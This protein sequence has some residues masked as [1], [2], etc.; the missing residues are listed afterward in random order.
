MLHCACLLFLLPY[1]YC[2]PHSIHLLLFTL[3]SKGR[4]LTSILQ[5]ARHTL[6]LKA[7][8][9]LLCQS[10]T[11]IMFHLLTLF[12]CPKIVADSGLMLNHLNIYTSEEAIFSMTSPEMKS[13]IALRCTLQFR[14]LRLGNFLLSVT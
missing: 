7:Q 2:E 4:F 12:H 8:R 13:F 1:L 9:S 10:S 6:V 14:E 11:F 5:H 3:R